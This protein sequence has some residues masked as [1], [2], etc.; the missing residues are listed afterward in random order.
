M[1]CLSRIGARKLFYG[2]LNLVLPAATIARWAEQ[3]AK[4]PHA[5]VSDTLVALCQKTGNATLDVLPATL[6]LA[7]SR[8]RS[9]KDAAALLDRLEGK[10]SDSAESLARLFGEEL[11]SGLVFATQ[12]E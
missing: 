7:A 1:W 6:N 8:L 4:Q 9:H 11:P 10:S 3:L 12:T 2:P 5:A